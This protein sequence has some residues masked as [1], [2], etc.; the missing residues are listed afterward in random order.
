VIPSIHG[1][2]GSAR[3]ERALIVERG[4]ETVSGD[5]RPVAAA[6]VGAQDHEPP[7]NRIAEDES[8][9]SIRERHRI[10][11]RFWVGVREL[12]RPRPAAVDRLVDPRAVSVANA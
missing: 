2:V 4:W 11:E 7:V 12:R 1:D 9:I 6:I 8:V 10:E 3:C 5:A